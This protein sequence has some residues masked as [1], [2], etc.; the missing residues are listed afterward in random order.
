MKGMR[1]RAVLAGVMAAALF[2]VGAWGQSDLDDEIARLKREVAERPTDAA[3][4]AWRARVVADW[5]DALSLK[6]FETG[7]DGPNIR[8]F[9]TTPPQGQAAV[10]Q[11][12]T[13]DRAIRELRMREEEPN[14]LGSLRA[15][16]LGPFEARGYATLR[17]IWTVGSRGMKP[18]G[19]F[20]VARHFSTNFGE[21]QTSDPAGENYVT[22]A[23]TDA[24]ARFAVDS[25]MA[26]GA[27]GG[28][29][30]PEP[31]LV[32]RLSAGQLDPG[33]SVTITYGDTS[34]GGP[35]ILLPTMSGE[36]MPLPLYVDLDGS[37]EWLNLPLLRF[38][39]TGTRVA[40]VHAFGPSIVTP[41]ERFELSVRAEDQYFNRATGAVPAFEVLVNG[42]VRATTPAG[43]EPISLLT[44]SLDQP[45]I[46]RVT[47]RSSDG[48]ITGEGNPI[49]VMRDPPFRI[50]WGDTHGH[51]GYAEGIGTVD[52]FMRFARDDA[53]LDFVTHSE[54]DTSL[55][56][57]EWELM[58][59]TNRQYDAPGRFVPFL[60]YE[61]TTAAQNGGHHNVLFRTIDGRERVSALEYPTLTRLYEA[62]RAT[63]NPNDVLVIPHAH[64]PGNYRHSDGDLEPLVEIMSMHGTFEWFG[65]AY[66]SH[67]HQVGFVAASD[68]HL[69]HP[70]YSAPS[71]DSL[72]Q[73]GGLGA[74]L[75]PGRSRDQLFD[76]MKAR[77]TYATTGDR[78]ILE[79]RLND[80]LMG[81]R[82]PY[83]PTRRVVGRV[84]GTAPIDSL[85]I[86]KNGR[87]I[88]EEHYLTDEGTQSGG[89]L[90]LQVSFRSDATPHHPG[91]APRGWRHWRGSLSV[92]GA[93]LGSIAPTDFFNPSTQWVRRQGNGAEFSTHTRGDSSSLRLTL[94]DASPAATLVLR[95][96]EAMETGSAPPFFRVHQRIPGGEVRLRVADLVRGRLDRA[97]PFQHYQDGIVLRQVVRDGRRDVEFDYTDADDP[98]QGDYYYV[99]VVQANDAMA[100]SSPIWVGGYPSR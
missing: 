8:R 35:G 68:D 44:L 17:Q 66:L 15:E 21:Y 91:D 2:G 43:R 58:R 92:E 70:G 83:S 96:E 89:T 16:S 37:G 9:A 38:V 24:D 48:R 18:G 72:A 61:W 25:I 34:R 75:A 97:M 67:G 98:R 49:L 22:I 65:Q 12:R 39:V 73:R 54:H 47:L 74:V 11:G 30:A 36:A 6:G 51:S 90:E 5:I 55:D 94:A 26:S 78:I 86:L 27:H 76:A 1:G 33:A 93:R 82:A 23:T 64:N 99:R 10:T 46:H 69:S 4:I 50:Y 14:A 84:F 60:G 20:W 56:K 42:V 57:G 29:R 52:Y 13:V 45:G 3:T 88:R 28:F 80:T 71:R 63:V 41:G 40:G 100:W 95:L 19:G 77:R 32:F 31:A 79:A 85:A 53:R 7:L 87:V 62:L 81:G 59:R